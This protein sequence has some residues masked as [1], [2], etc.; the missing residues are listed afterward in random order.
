MRSFYF[1]VP[2]SLLGLVV[3]F[4]SAPALR[5]VDK[6]NMP[7]R[8]QFIGAT[9]AIFSQALPAAASAK[10]TIELAGISFTPAAMVLQMAEQTAAMEGIMRQS[11]KDMETLTAQQRDEAAARNEGPGVIGRGDMYK[12]VDVM[13]ANSKLESLPNGR[14][15]AQTLRG[16]QLA[17]KLGKGPLAQDEYV[18]MANQYKAA[19]EELRRGFES[20][21]REEQAE[22]KAIIRGVQMRDQAMVKK[23]EEEAEKL[24]LARAR[25]AE[26]PEAPPKRTKTL[27]ELEEAQAAAF[28]KEA[29]QPTLS[30]YGR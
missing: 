27:K 21:S 29:R 4:S 19:R 17:C 24:Q 23:Y 20:M 18:G 25:I 30:L 13:I 7:S 1:H 8:R 9:S 15:A 28:G 14:E 22:G 26:E 5:V 10:D 12:S 3:L 11:A 6:L 16:I 2:P